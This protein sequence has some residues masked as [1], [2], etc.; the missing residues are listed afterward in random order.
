MHPLNVIRAMGPIDAK[1][2]GRDSLLA[3]MG[4]LPLFI[5]LLGRAVFPPIIAGMGEAIGIDLMP[6]YP[7]MM[8]YVLL[9]VTPFM[10]GMVIGFLLLDQRDDRT[11]TAL[12]VTPM[13]LR[14][15]LIYRLAGPML[16]SL[17]MTVVALPLAGLATG[18]ML[19][20]VAGALV[21]APLAPIVAL[22][23]AS[24]AQNKVQGFALMKASGIFMW[25][26]IIAYFVPP[27]WQI[28]FG[29]VPTYWAPR[30][31]SVAEA[32]EAI[33]WLYLV[34]GLAYQALVIAALLR[35]FDRVMYR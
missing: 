16:V 34:A 25:P 17:V 18:G 22:S 4:L 31:Y 24:F 3:W 32:G 13:P 29:L 26:P 2:V 20:V 11:L 28:P 35:R 5:A 6:Y 10:C 1:S 9:L 23:L 15:Y 12:Q 7:V 30:V 14:S 27:L 19:P 8:G 21:A 33:L